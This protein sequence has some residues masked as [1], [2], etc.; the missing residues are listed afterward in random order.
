[1]T[2]TVCL[3]A[4]AQPVLPFWGIL[5]FFTPVNLGHFSHRASE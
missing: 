5:P 3:C 2:V 1:M 4:E